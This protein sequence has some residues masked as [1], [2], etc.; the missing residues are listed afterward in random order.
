MMLL[1]DSQAVLSL[2]LLCEEL[3]ATLMDGTRRISIVD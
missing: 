3:G 2:G 1:E